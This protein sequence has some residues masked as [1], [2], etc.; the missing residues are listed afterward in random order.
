MDLLTY[1]R[2]SLT[3]QV[4]ALKTWSGL[5]ISFYLM[6]IEWSRTSGSTMPSRGDPRLDDSA[7]R[8]LLRT[9]MLYQILLIQCFVPASL[10]SCHTVVRQ[11]KEMAMILDLTHRNC[12]PLAAA[13]G[14]WKLSSSLLVLNRSVM[15]RPAAWW[16]SGKPAG[17]KNLPTE[18]ES[19]ACSEQNKTR[20]T[21]TRTRLAL[22]VCA[23]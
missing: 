23:I 10:T 2:A 8:W 17:I 12:L 16:I 7:V 6:A 14:A 19:V 5:H 11:G 21:E 22:V 9:P 13:S 4:K 15:L 3:V 20:W 1:T 18:E